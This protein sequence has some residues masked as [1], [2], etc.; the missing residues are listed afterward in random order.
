MIRWL[1]PLVVAFALPANALELALAG[2]TPTLT[3]SIEA[4]SVR[5]PDAPWSENAPP[6]EVEGAINRTVLRSPGGARTTLQLLAPLRDQLSAVGFQQVFSCADR[7]CGGFDFRF[8]L[9]LLPAPEMFVDLGDYRYLLMRREG[10]DPH[11]VSIVTSRSTGA[12]FIH[13]TTLGSAIIPDIAAPA[14]AV[15]TLPQATADVIVSL[16][17]RGHA[18]L[19]DLDFPS[20]SSTLGPGTFASLT[21]LA[22]WM[23]ANPNARVAL[24]GHTDSVGGADANQTLS[25]RRAASVRSRLIEDAGIAPSR[26]EAAGVGYLAPVAPNTTEDGRAANRRV[27]VV[28]LSIE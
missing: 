6:P 17:S 18:V 19:G 15:A 16:T 25:E 20:G 9:D 10:G 26:V 14:E 4:G 22:E 24:V 28:L 21:E 11:T 27:E 7:A 13:I 1:A 5:L 23:G 3:E 8:Q 12:G 2:A